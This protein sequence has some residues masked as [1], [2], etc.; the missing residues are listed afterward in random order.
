MRKLYGWG[1]FVKLDKNEPLIGRS[2]NDI[3]TM[4]GQGAVGGRQSRRNGLG[5]PRSRQIP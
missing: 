1:K 3:V 2:I 5:D 4:Q